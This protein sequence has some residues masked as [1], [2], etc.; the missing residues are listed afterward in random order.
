LKYNGYFGVIVERVRFSLKQPNAP[1]L[2]NVTHDWFCDDGSFNK[3]P[4]CNIK[5]MS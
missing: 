5:V 2:K 3:N 1:E 4:K